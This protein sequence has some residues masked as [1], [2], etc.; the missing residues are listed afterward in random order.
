MTK[1]TR[2]LT[3]FIALFAVVTVT[4]RTIG[5]PTIAHA[6]SDPENKIL[7]TVCVELQGFRNTE[8]DEP[9]RWALYA[10]GT[11]TIVYSDTDGGSTTA[12][13]STP[14]TK[15]CFEPI[16]VPYAVYDLYIKGGDH[17]AKKVTN[18]VYHGYGTVD[19][20]SSVTLYEG[21][22]DNNN[23][24]NSADFSIAMSHLQYPYM[25]NG[26]DTCP[27]FNEDN[28][29]TPTDL[30]LLVNN[31]TFPFM[32]GDTITGEMN[33]ITPTVT[34]TTAENAGAIGCS[35]IPE[36]VEG[37]MVT[38]D[39]MVDLTT[40]QN[41]IQGLINFDPTVLEFITT[42]RGVDFNRTALE[43]QVNDNGVILSYG[44]DND[45][46]RVSDGVGQLDFASVT[47]Q[48]LSATDTALTFVNDGTFNGSSAYNNG[49][50]STLTAE[51]CVATVTPPIITPTVTPT[52]VAPVSD[53]YETDD[54]CDAAKSISTDGTTQLHT[55][56]TQDDTDWVM[57]DAVANTTYEITG[58]S[59]VGQSDDFAMDLFADCTRPV[60]E[61]LRTSQTKSTSNL[62]SIIFQA[63]ETKRYYL[64]LSRLTADSSLTSYQLFVRPLIEEAIPTGAIVIINGRMSESD[65]LQSNINTVTDRIHQFSSTFLPEEA[66]FYL[67]TDPTLAGVDGMPT[68]ESLHTILT[69]SVKPY[70][71]DQKALTLFWIPSDEMG[72]LPL[73]LPN[74][75]ETTA[76]ELSLWLTQLEEAI[77]GLHI[78]IVL[79][80]CNSGAFISDLTHRLSKPNR[81]II[82]S[83]SDQGL[84]FASTD[85]S[86]FFDP[87]FK[88][89]KTSGH[90]SQAFQ[91]A[92]DRLFRQTAWLD[93]NGNG[94]PNELADDYIASYRLF[95]PGTP[96]LWSPSI[97]EMTFMR[98]NDEQFTLTVT[99]QN[100][101][102]T[103]EIGELFVVLYPISQTIPLI[104]DGFVDISGF[105]TVT[106]QSAENNTYQTTLSS[107]EIQNRQ[108]GIYAKDTSGVITALQLINVPADLPTAVKLS[109]AESR[110]NDIAILLGVGIGLLF[111]SAVLLSNR[112]RA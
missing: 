109:S 89:L 22:A 57:F 23:V 37:E 105:P 111:A 7:D 107:S 3:F 55:F 40:P 108:I 72:V 32:T 26:P 68:K 15:G 45:I 84:A 86:Q 85:G 39:L 29:S 1:I 19:L 94:I 44:R 54:S 78:N 91:S 38:F 16:G 65:R 14:G 97:L 58:Q 103:A 61:F 4:A 100:D 83:T 30:S 50:L 52:P 79:D 12:S 77:P 59:S 73:D 88:E 27:D 56:H 49:I 13:I 46:V 33:T 17:L 87:F 10:P 62:G 98:D 6:M 2:F 104:T 60:N 70:L 53:A 48:V 43:T 25:S 66:I 71:S 92:K 64:K 8:Q 76:A 24:I 81:L 36:L 75:E 69:E 74:H 41:A 96:A 47:F 63:P 51:S 11:S 90:F 106:L 95:G 42:T 34:P 80:G 67:A 82:T 102:Q 35:S 110:P 21:D 101:N 99:L 112:R 18:W 20:S 31:M 5:S 28:M 9:V 93:A